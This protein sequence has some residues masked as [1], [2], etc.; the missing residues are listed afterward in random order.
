MSESVDADRVVAAAALYTAKTG[1]VG[2]Q[3]AWRRVRLLAI[4]RQRIH[5][6]PS[7][8]PSTRIGT[9]QHASI[10][11]AVTGTARSIDYP[12]SSPDCA[13]VAAFS[14]MRALRFNRH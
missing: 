1:R 11:V 13:A 7:R 8:I 9:A 2:A 14:I 4:T 6:A 3:V 10:C 5:R 12:Y